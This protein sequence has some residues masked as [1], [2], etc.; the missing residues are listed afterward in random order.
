MA[1][2]VP[3]TPGCA[4]DQNGLHARV[5]VLEP[6]AIERAKKLIQNEQHERHSTTLKRFRDMA[7]G[8]SGAHTPD[9][10]VM[11]SNSEG[12]SLSGELTRVE[13]GHIVIGSGG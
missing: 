12:S 5:R 3:Y 4:C 13:I 8:S 11:R 6:L 1:E 9:N 2:C 7:S 10:P